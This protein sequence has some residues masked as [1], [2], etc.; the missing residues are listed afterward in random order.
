MKYEYKCLKIPLTAGFFSN[1]VD[2]NL[3]EKTLNV[4]GLDGWEVISVIDTNEGYG[5]SKEIVVTMKRT[6]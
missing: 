5:A 4:H 3:L 2:E 1:K 6:L